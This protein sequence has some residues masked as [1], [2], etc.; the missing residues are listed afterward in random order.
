MLQPAKLAGSIAVSFAAGAVG[1]LATIPNIPTWYMSLHKPF[2]NP[3][4]WI[5]GPV[6]TLLY[7]LVAISLY[8]VWTAQYKASKKNALGVFGIQLLLNAAWTVVFFGAHMTV[9]GVVVILLLL[10]SILLTVKLFW[11]ISKVAV[12]LLIPYAVWVAFATALTIAI[13]VLN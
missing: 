5:F 7:L 3:P 12:Y 8:L 2:F 9:V 11:P 6:W 10:G 4:N 1:S 13:A